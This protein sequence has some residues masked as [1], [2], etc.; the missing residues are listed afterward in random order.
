MNVMNLRVNDEIWI[1]GK[2]PSLDYFDFSK[3]GIFRIGINEAAFDIPNCWAALAVDKVVVEKYKLLL[4]PSILLFLP[5]FYTVFNL[6][7]LTPYYIP[8]EI[9][10]ITSGQAALFIAHKLG[11]T[12]IHLIGFDSLFGNFKYAG[13]YPIIRNIKEDYEPG[14]ILIREFVKKELVPITFHC[15]GKIH[16]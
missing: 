14:N 5:T 2:G 8:E 9:P 3:A 16:V 13:N 10:T 4:D 12:H 15:K 7:P 1:F 11:A 6:S